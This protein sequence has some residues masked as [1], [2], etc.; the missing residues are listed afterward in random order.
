MSWWP[1]NV[2]LLRSIALSSTLSSSN[3]S[4]C[5]LMVRLHKEAW[6]LSVYLNL[7]WKS[8]KI[9]LL[10]QKC[11]FPI[12]ALKLDRRRSYNEFHFLKD[13]YNFPLFVSF[14]WHTLLSFYQW[15]QMLFLNLFIFI[16][17]KTEMLNLFGGTNDFLA[18]QNRF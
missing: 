10:P 7:E 15:Q 12:W 3:T 16:F 4:K 13:R 2:I 6:I 18:A 8:E 9:G 17:L 11:L 1:D 14:Y 5:A